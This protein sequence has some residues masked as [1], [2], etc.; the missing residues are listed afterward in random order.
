MTKNLLNENAHL[1]ERECAVNAQEPS[2]FV[3]APC[4]TAPR[5]SCLAPV[6]LTI[7]LPPIRQGE[8]IIQRSIGLN[9]L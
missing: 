6:E 1:P 9:Y 7:D 5:R 3:N 8:T 2:P 4:S